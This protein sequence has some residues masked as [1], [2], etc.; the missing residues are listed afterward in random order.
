MAKE[1][2]ISVSITNYGNGNINCTMAQ[3]IDAEPLEITKL[4]K[5]H[6]NKLIWELKLAGGK[7]TVR[8]NSLDPSIYT[9]DAYLFLP[10]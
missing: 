6:A 8:V 5:D 3:G 1:I 7:R 10:Y 2:Y 4:D 9:V